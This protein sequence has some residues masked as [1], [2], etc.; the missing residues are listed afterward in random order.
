M[1]K[2]KPAQGGREV[3]IT[4]GPPENLDE[5]AAEAP[6]TE[7]QKKLITPEIHKYLLRRANHILPPS[8]RAY[9]IDKNT[10]ANE[11]VDDVLIEAARK[12]DSGKGATFT[13]YAVRLLDYRM[14][15]RIRESGPLSRT[16]QQYKKILAYGVMAHS[17]DATDDDLARILGTTPKK[18]HQMKSVLESQRAGSPK[19]PISGD[20]IENQDEGY[21]S[22]L[23]THAD[24]HVS[25]VQRT[26]HQEALAVLLA[27]IEKSEVL[28]QR[29][30]AIIKDHL[31]A[32]KRFKDIGKEMGMTESRAC[33][34]YNGALLK[35][36][37]DIL[38]HLKE[39]DFL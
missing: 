17:A 12:F 23:T 8:N 24:P 3:D 35:I 26:D 21:D 9:G 32:G 28:D 10:L 5:T 36:Q 30:I 22:P 39:E 15:D 11:V 31:L 6:L 7:E 19:N 20:H 37:N 25:E 4:N 2:I 14:V 38:P 27:I 29:E 33:Q 16:A 13:T 18:I 34:I 1:E